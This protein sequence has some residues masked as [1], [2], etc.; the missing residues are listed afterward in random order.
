MATIM[1]S[2]DMQLISSFYAFP[3]FNRKYGKQL[4]NGTWQVDADW[5]LGLSLASLIGLIFGVFPTFAAGTLAVFLLVVTPIMHNFWGVPSRQQ[6]QEMIHFLKNLTMLGAA[7]LF[8]AM[9][10]TAWPYAV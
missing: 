6:E 5:Q 8:L 2:Y 10:A 9:S 4:P 1:E 3:Q 7:L